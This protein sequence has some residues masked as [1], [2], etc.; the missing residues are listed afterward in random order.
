MHL[1]LVQ[2]CLKVVAGGLNMFRGAPNETFGLCTLGWPGY[3]SPGA[4]GCLVGPP[5]NGGLSLM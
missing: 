5:A 4:C 2:G 3:K 1:T